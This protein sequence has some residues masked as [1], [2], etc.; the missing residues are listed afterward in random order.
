MIDLMSVKSKYGGKEFLINV[1]HITAIN[2]QENGDVEIYV[3]DGGSFQVEGTLENIR[4]NVL[5]T[6][7]VR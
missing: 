7:R 3:I 1:H 5:Q 2:E 6:M 4:L